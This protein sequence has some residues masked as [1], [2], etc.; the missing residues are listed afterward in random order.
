MGIG[1]AGLLRLLLLLRGS[2]SYSLRR[3]RRRRRQFVADPAALHSRPN[4]LQRSIVRPSQWSAVVLAACN[5]DKA[6]QLRWPRSY[7][8][9]Q[10]GFDAR[11]KRLGHASDA[12]QVRF[13]Q[14]AKDQFQY[15]RRQFE[16][17]ARDGECRCCDLGLFRPRLGRL[18][19]RLNHSFF[20]CPFI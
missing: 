18:G 19:P 17:G 11:L 10:E 2:S 9:F 3:R 8:A 16:K 7:P 5:P 4:K 6:K 20:R 14:V 15:F 12:E 1:I 13:G